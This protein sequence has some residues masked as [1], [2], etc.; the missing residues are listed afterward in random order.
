MHESM[1]D[2]LYILLLTIN[3]LSTVTPCIC[4]ASLKVIT[5]TFYDNHH[6]QIISFKLISKLFHC[7]QTLNGL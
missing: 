7:Q 3:K 4:S 5:E 6:L 2:V 1:Q